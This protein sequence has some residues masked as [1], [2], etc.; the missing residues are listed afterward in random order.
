[1]D[2]LGEGGEVVAAAACFF[3]Q[4]DGGGLSGEQENFA[5]RG[6]C[7]VSMMARSMPVIPGMTTSE[8]RRSG[9][10]FLARFT[11][12]G[13]VIGGH[14]GE[15]ASGEDDGESVGDDLFVVDDEHDWVLSLGRTMASSFGT[16][17]SGTTVEFQIWETWAVPLIH[18]RPVCVDTG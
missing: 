12:G 11:R 4:I 17:L 18:R 5:R 8:M 7:C 13:S 3:E 6:W 14:C 1:M 16:S 15:A 2:W 9:G 10:D